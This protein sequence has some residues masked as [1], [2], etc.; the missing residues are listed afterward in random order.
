MLKSILLSLNPASI[1]PYFRLD[2]FISTYSGF[3]AVTASTLNLHFLSA[4]P[5]KAFKFLTHVCPR[6][7]GTFIAPERAHINA[8]QKKIAPEKSQSFRV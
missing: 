1:Y 8:K 5:S 4:N 7:S 2:L 6:G 3:V